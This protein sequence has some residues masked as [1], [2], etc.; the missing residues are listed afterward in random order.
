MNEE[1]Q[2]LLSLEKYGGDKLAKAYKSFE[3]Q[4]VAEADKV[5]LSKA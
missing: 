4:L 1:I 3:D 2:S 5:S